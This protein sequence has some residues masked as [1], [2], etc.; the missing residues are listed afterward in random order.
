MGA[1]FQGE[2]MKLK[3][4]QVGQ[5]QTNCYVLYEEGHAIVI[6]PGDEGKRIRHFL[7][8]Q[9]LELDM[10][11]LTHGH[12]DHTMAV[13]YLYELFSSP[14]YIDEGDIEYCS[15]TRLEG[16]YAIKSPHCQYPKDLHWLSYPIEIV[17]IPGHSEGSVLIHIQDYYFS[18]DVLFVDGIG[19]YDLVGGDFE[20]LMN[21]ID[22][23][24]QLGDEC[25]FYPGHEEPFTLEEAKGKNKYLR[26]MR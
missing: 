15:S 22:Y 16:A 3:R 17:S 10:I 6:D 1:F 21:S 13:D 14:I 4:I 9:E 7:Q 26:D 23:L 11:L 18:G 20:A 12:C 8:K 5:E 24:A 19:R 2:Y 25:R